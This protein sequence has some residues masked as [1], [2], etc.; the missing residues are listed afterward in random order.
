MRITLAVLLL[1][2]MVAMGAG[3]GVSA[4]QQPLTQDLTRVEPDMGTEADLLKW[5]VTQG[6]LTLV[7]VLVL[8]SYRR[9]FFR[10][11][12][13]KDAEILALR[14]EKRE[15]VAV[16]EKGADANIRQAVAIAA[17]TEATKLLA[18]NVNNLAERRSHHRD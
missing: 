7:L 10:K 12:A 17:N 1:C 16:L 6:A 13:A 5:S 11:V 3:G 15:L 18:Q 4:Q 8:I 9:D 14:E 2:A